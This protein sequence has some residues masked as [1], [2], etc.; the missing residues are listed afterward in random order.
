M[1]FEASSNLNTGFFK[2]VEQARLGAEIQDKAEQELIRQHEQIQQELGM[3]ADFQRA[4]LPEVVNLPYLDVCINYRPYAQASG[5]VYDFPQNR[6]GELS[7][8]LGD[9]TG[10][11]I[12]AALMR[13][14]IHI[15]LDGIRRDLS[16][17]ESVRI[18]NR[19]IA[20]RETGRSVS[21]YFTALRRAVI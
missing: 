2:V 21:A 13:M 14:M 18:L 17:D 8:F 1:S 7:M 16:T 9:A 19:L 11:G 20:L 12:A 10:H 6:E 3:A 5:D 15:G 4:V